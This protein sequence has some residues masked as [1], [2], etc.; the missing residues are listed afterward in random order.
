MKTDVEIKDISH[1]LYE[2]ERIVKSVR[3]KLA[4]D[5]GLFFMRVTTEYEDELYV[6]MQLALVLLLQMTWQ[7]P[8]AYSLEPKKTAEYLAPHKIT[9]EEILRVLKKIQNVDLVEEKKEGAFKGHYLLNHSMFALRV[10]KALGFE[11]EVEKHLKEAKE[12]A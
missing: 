6:D 8:H 9:K 11:A 2:L 10:G 12:R 5:W 4:D 7:L 3:L 1:R